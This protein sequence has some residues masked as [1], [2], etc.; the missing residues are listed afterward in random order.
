MDGRVD[1]FETSPVDG[2]AL[3]HLRQQRTIAQPALVSSFGF[4]SG[5]DVTVQFR[6]AAPNTGVVFVRGDY[7]IP[8]RI[9]AQ[10]EFRIEVPRR[11]TLSRD[12]ATVEMVEHILAALAG[13]RVDNCEVWVDAPEMPGCDGSSLAFVEALKKAKVVEQ[14]A[15]R[16]Q[17]LVS[18]ITR[19]GDEH[20]WVEA[21]PSRSNALQVKYRLDY[22]DNIAIGRQSL[23]LDITTE[24][25][26]RDLAPARTFLVEQEAEWLQKQGLGTRVTYNDVLIFN[27]S[28]PIDNELRFE[29]ECVRHKVLDL[30]G[31]LA[32]VGCDV[33][34]KIIAHR[35]GH[36]LNAELVRA[37]RTECQI[38]ESVRRTA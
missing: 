11:T 18:E 15:Q 34:G 4:W 28:E 33:V 3:I 5:R 8:R 21:R 38:V 12:G 36:R 19:V 7:E 16:P 17:M 27:E 1:D 13:M 6:P 9:P 37:L 14:N 25:F 23:E 26:C 29:D 24:S 35:S 10:A 20:C 32:L 22:P 30:V 31:D 2:S